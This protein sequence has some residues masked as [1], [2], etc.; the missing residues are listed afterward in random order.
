MENPFIGP[1]SFR[2]GETLYGR[3]QDSQE[4]LD[5][6][7]SE[8]IVL[9]FAPS[10]AGK[11]SLIEAKLRPGLV[12]E[13]LDVLPTMRL[14]LLPE[15][16]VPEGTNP[17]MLSLLLS[18]DTSLGKETPLQELAEYSL[19]DY[20]EVL[21]EETKQRLDLTEDEYF[22]VLIFDEFELSLTWGPPDEEYARFR[23]E[24]FQELGRV[25]RKTHRWALFAMREEFLA[26]LEPYLRWI[27]TQLATTFRLDLLTK[28]AAAEAIQGPAEAH[29]VRF[30]PEALDHLLW[31]LS[32]VKVPAPGG[33]IDEHEG[34]FIEPVQLQV[35]CL[36]LWKSLDKQGAFEDR[37]IDEDEIQNTVGE[38][39]QA[40]ASFYDDVVRK[41]VRTSGIDERRLRTWISEKLL[42]KR[43]I[44]TQTQFVQSLASPLGQALQILQQNLIIRSESR[45][46]VDWLELTHDRLIAP[47]KESN[48]RWR[49]EQLS[50]LQRRAEEWRQHR[51]DPTLLLQ[52]QVLRTE[53]RRI[54]TS[55]LASN[56]ARFL[57]ACKK[58][59]RDI[60]LQRFLIVFAFIALAIW[61]FREINLKE[62]FRDLSNHA[63]SFGL[64]LEAQRQLDQHNPEASMHLARLAYAAKEKLKERDEKRFVIDDK[65][66]YETLVEARKSP[67]FTAYSIGCSATSSGRP[68]EKPSES[69]NS[70]ISARAVAFAPKGDYFAATLCGHLIE[71]R[72]LV[73]FDGKR[74]TLDISQTV[75]TLGFSHD[76]QWLAA[77]GSEGTLVVYPKSWWNKAQDTQETRSYDPILRQDIATIRA[78]AFHPHRLLFASAGEGSEIHLWSLDEDSRQ[79]K[80]NT[81]LVDDVTGHSQFLRDGKPNEVRSLAWDPH[82][83][84]L[85]SGGSDG[86]IVRWAISEDGSFE[87]DGTFDIEKQRQ[88]LSNSPRIPIVR[89]LAFDPGGRILAAAIDR[90]NKTSELHW[91]K[92]ND[93]GIVDL[94]Y[95]I[96][97][98]HI[99]RSLAWI[100]G[101][102]R[103]NQLAGSSSAGEILLWSISPDG[104]IGLEGEGK[105]LLG[106]RGW[107]FQIAV[108]PTG[109]FLA[110]ASGDRDR[111]VRL[112][113]ARTSQELEPAKDTKPKDHENE[114]IK[115]K[116]HRLVVTLDGQKMGFIGPDRQRVFWKTEE[117]F[118]PLSFTDPRGDSTEER[119]ETLTAIALSKDQLAVASQEGILRIW[120]LNELQF[121]DIPQAFPQKIFTGEGEISELAFSTDSDNQL[122]ATGHTNGTVLIFET[123]APQHPPIRIENSNQPVTALTFAGKQYL[124]SE[125]GEGKQTIPLLSTLLD[126]ARTEARITTCDELNERKFIKNTED[127]QTCYTYRVLYQDDQDASKERGSL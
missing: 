17:L 81:T 60:Y 84:W 58:A 78:L 22:N 32:R 50:L 113:Q 9:L 30:K 96:E 43:G 114:E 1:R 93:E 98:P 100:P 10:G 82:G 37:L 3:A 59:Q 15:D 8:R 69:A 67:Y 13:G 66:L 75:R 62:Q 127:L 7:I 83:R 52:G 61:I 39:D 87:V 45:R 125:H 91:W 57:E 107:V 12:E 70:S 109:Q 92:T 6:L 103:Q 106:H 77:G 74:T 48:A 54:E 88:L 23:Q 71:I 40:L 27:P 19:S 73:E 123:Q 55:K 44:R 11:S 90:G 99:L 49:E 108:D 79:W 34:L 64:A 122:L 31:D 14:R 124:F 42:T 118:A 86:K 56:D 80:W 16:P 20:L 68:S 112:W 26:E 25:L 24:L 116:T 117:D 102:A 121:A 105:R 46:G 89:S 38:V 53:T 85:T 119:R 2:C 104:E 115:E 41:A 36:R 111:S 63:E 110:S 28:A 51:Q 35:V 21:E 101:K 33:T 95:S 97:H 72:N 94:H 65:T 120:A 126:Q 29:G 76:G 47:V 4:L 5:R 18:L